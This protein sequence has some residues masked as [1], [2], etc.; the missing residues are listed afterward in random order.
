VSGIAIAVDLDAVL[1][2]TR[3]VWNAWLEDAA[4]RSRVELEVPEDRQAAAGVLDAALGDW[5]PLLD[6]FAADR[7]PLW[8][9][10]R[11]ET[12]A[13]L[14]RLTRAGARIG[15][16]TDAPRELAELALAHTGAARYLEVV[17]TLAEVRAELGQDAVLVG[18]REEL[19]GLR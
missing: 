10:P 14:R 12:N 18:S 7:A 16:S 11:A 17:G 13:A 4:R 6:R 15:A 19:A 1:A 3:P 8:F 9:R 2:D 5:R